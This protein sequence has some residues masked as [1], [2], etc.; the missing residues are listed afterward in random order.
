MF[1][2]YNIR[3]WKRLNHC[4]EKTLAK[5][6]KHTQKLEWLRIQRALVLKI[7]LVLPLQKKKISSRNHSKSFY[8]ALDI[9]CISTLAWPFFCICRIICIPISYEKKKWTKI[10]LISSTSKGLIKDMIL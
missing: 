2:V 9:L 3:F 7:R 4:A 5:K 10:K 1:L 8:Q 6:D